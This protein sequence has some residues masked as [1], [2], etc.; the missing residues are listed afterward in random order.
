MKLIIISINKDL[1]HAFIN[2][3]SPLMYF[4]DKKIKQEIRKEKNQINLIFN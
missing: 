3:K 2:V 4:Y 1:L